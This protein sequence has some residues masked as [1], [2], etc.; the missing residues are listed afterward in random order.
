LAQQN[1]LAVGE[2][3]SLE[4]TE[5][6]TVGGIL[7]LTDLEAEL[8]QVL[9]DTPEFV[10]LNSTD[11]SRILTE[12]FQ[13]LPLPQAYFVD[14]PS[15]E[16]EELLLDQLQNVLLQRAGIPTTLFNFVG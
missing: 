15:Q 2:P 4:E 12:R 7:D 5:T 3:I 16:W 10:I 13:E 8:S 1:G 11:F 6:F 9:T 14:D